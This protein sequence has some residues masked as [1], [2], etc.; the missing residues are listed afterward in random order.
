VTAAAARSVLGDTRYGE[1]Y[2]RGQ[3]VT[4]D[5]LAALVPVTNGTVTNGTVTPGA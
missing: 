3:R 4:V 1:A 2:Q 5:T